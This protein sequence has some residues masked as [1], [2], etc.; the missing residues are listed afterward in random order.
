MR[1]IKSFVTLGLVVGVVSLV[2]AAQSRNKVGG[3]YIVYA[4]TAEA[5]GAV[6]FSHLSHG[7]SVAGFGCSGC[8]P[9]IAK[10]RGATTKDTVH[11]G[12][13]CARCHDG[14]TKGPKSGRLAP[15]VN[16]C[17]SCHM[18]TT[19][20]AIKVDSI[21]D[22]PFS[23]LEHTGVVKDGKVV[24]HGGQS[25]GDCHTELFTA[26]NGL[27]IAWTYPHGN[28]RCGECHNGETTSPSTGKPIFNAFSANCR[29]CH[30]DPATGQPCR[31]G[32]DQ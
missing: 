11:E 7:K 20:S 17:Q 26:K 23:H 9:T 1:H 29:R 30:A 25:C 28:D 15:D 19:E 5:P 4:A 14:K 12:N 31:K 16:N 24:Q 6:V 10:K 13:A 21:G 32:A 27:S 3:G 2:W 8:H 18:P 22:V